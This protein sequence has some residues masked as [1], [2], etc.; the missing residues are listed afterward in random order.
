MFKKSL[1]FIAA[2]LLL[3][4]FVAAQTQGLK[5]IDSQIVIEEKNTKD[6]AI[7]VAP[8]LSSGNNAFPT[9][10][11]NAFTTLTL[12]PKNVSTADPFFVGELYAI[13]TCYFW[14]LRQWTVTIRADESNPNRFWFSDLMPQRLEQDIY[15][16][17][18]PQNIEV[19]ADLVEN[20]LRFPEGQ[21]M[22]DET[23]PSG[24]PVWLMGYDGTDFTSDG[25]IE[26]YVNTPGGNITFLKGYGS[27]AQTGGSQ[28]QGYWNGILLPGVIYD[29]DK[30]VQPR[31]LAP[32]GTLYFAYSD[33]GDTWGWVD[34][35]AVNSAFYTWHWEN[36]FYSE[37][38]TYTWT[39]NEFL[40]RINDIP[41][42]AP[43][44]TSNDIHLSMPVENM[45]EFSFPL[46]EAETPTGKYG[47][48]QLN[49]EEGVDRISIIR[50]GGGSS[51][52]GGR[53]YNLT[54]AN[55]IFS[56]TCYYSG[57]QGEWIYGS[58]GQSNALIHIFEK[59]LSTLY[60][61]GID[62]W[63]NSDFMAP[64]GTTFKIEIYDYDFDENG[65]LVLGDNLLAAARTLSN[66][67]ILGE[68]YGMIRF[69]NMFIIDEWGFE[70]PI[71][72][73][74]VDHGIAVVF[75]GY[76]VPGVNVCIRCERF[77]RP[78]TK[79]FSYQLRA[80]QG[81]IYAR[82]RNSMYVYLVNG[83]Y[84]Y[85]GVPSLPDKVLNVSEGGGNYTFR[86]I[87]YYN[88]VELES[89]LPN[90]ITNISF[91]D[92]FG[93]VNWYSDATI[94]VSSLPQEL[95]GR[96][97]YLVFKTIGASVT[98]RVIQGDVSYISSQKLNSPI[99]ATTP[100]GLELSYP[101]DF[102]KA[103]VYNLSGQVVATYQLPKS[104]QLSIPANVMSR[105]IYTI[106]FIGK[107]TETVKVVR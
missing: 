33:D 104:G 100:N 59:P 86:L 25:I 92:D 40:E 77:D 64:S 8:R 70:T 102:N 80:Q 99:V 13:A 79:N 91:V 82:M 7:D 60:F 72:Y 19:Y 41:Q 18:N 20:T 65:D 83:M 103:V 66:N 67:V 37:D 39:V 14:D 88:V 12:K 15:G 47:S 55:R 22:W 11:E 23:H 45:K 75:S 51:S 56:S 85:V 44:M 89:D 73:L 49:T 34:N 52:S 46:L 42:Y 90:W 76:N 2:N 98:V 101:A 32:E 74:E 4:S 27:Q 97:A 69:R 96:Q 9:K 78:D 31:Y 1:F 107:T 53:N 68:N 58:G 54:N 3:I 94:T 84:S 21:D 17:F 6:K 16:N 95:A 57:E 30:P 38:A 106:Q 63:I 24:G 36:L 28:G 29:V 81:D 105:G 48:F 26:A 87:P 71:D 5:T 35:I 61:E 50:A 93:S 43:Y 10:I 62:F